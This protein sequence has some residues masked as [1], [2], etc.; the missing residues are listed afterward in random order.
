MYAAYHRIKKA[1]GSVCSDQ[2][3]LLERW[4]SHFGA[5]EA[6]RAT[7]V[8]ALVEEAL[9]TSGAQQEHWPHP[10][11][12]DC[13]PTEAFLQRTLAS[14]KLGKDRKWWGG[15]EAVP[16]SFIRN[17]ASF[18]EVF[19]KDGAALATGRAHWLQCGLW[20]PSGPAQLP[21]VRR[22]RVSVLRGDHPVD[23]IMQRHNIGSGLCQITGQPNLTAE[24]VADIRAHLQA[25]SAM[26]TAGS[27]AW[28]EALADNISG[29]N[30]F[31]LKNDVVPVRTYRGTRPG[32]AFADVVFAL[33][34]PRV[35]ALRDAL[36][37]SAIEHSCAPVLPWDGEFVLKACTCEDSRSSV[38]VSE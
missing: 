14:A 2:G 6:G 28:L 5:L 23:R 19:R 27:N 22:H 18:K 21:C 3:E 24:D 16:S 8:L 25:D 1:D 30:W 26:H 7:S 37:S 31:I 12:T 36:R 10:E 20:G 15:K 9:A 38:T 17:E 34:I 29:G 11:D 4:R 13:A 33:L 35:L 32:S